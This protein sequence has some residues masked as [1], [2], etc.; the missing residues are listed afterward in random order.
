M[1]IKINEDAVKTTPAPARGSVTLWDADTKGFGFRVSAPTPRHPKGARSFFLNYRVNGIERRMT[2]G[3]YPT[4]SALAAR[5]EARELR[6]R[7]DRGGDPAREK[8]EAREVPTLADLFERYEREHLTHKAPSSQAADRAMIK[9]YILP[10]LG[11]RKVADIHLGDIKALHRKIT[12]KGKRVR[13]NRVLA[14]ASSMFA[15]SLKP[16]AGE[17]KPWRDAAM[18]NPCKG[19]KRNRE[20]G[21]ERF[22]S[23]AELAE[24][25]DALSEIGDTPGA[26]FFRLMML[27]GCRP[28]EVMRATWEQFDVEPGF[29]VKP[30]ST[31]KQRSVHRAPLSPPA[32]ELIEKLR[33]QKRD[34]DER[35]LQ[36]RGNIQAELKKTWK[37]VRAHAKLKKGDRPYD[38]RHSFASVGVGG[39]LSLP[40]IGKLLG[41]SNP[42]ITARY[43][44][45]GDD[46]LKEAATKIGAAIAGAGKDGDKVVRPRFGK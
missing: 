36:F 27:T 9:A 41:H 34:S 23:A 43:A 32:L 16:M 19:I 42:K 15:L 5:T 6:K 11:R 18:G 4:W 33:A 13:A 44:H 14:V 8:R 45:L 3:E 26:D 46:P 40:I 25:G 20:E 37:A 1:P 7:V 28:V 35:V 31:T 21:R 17:T 10:E 29:W 39:G 30:A 22:F 2:I 12:E 38:L 24:I